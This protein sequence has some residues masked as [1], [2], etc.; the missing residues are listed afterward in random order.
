L[1]RGIDSE[2]VAKLAGWTPIPTTYAGGATSL[3]DL[4]DVTRAGKGR[5]DLTIGSALDIF[6]GTGV[7]YDNVV[8]FN[9]RHQGEVAR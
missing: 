4:E 7:K 9:R 2:L 1:C 6:G 8:A 5:I 3:N